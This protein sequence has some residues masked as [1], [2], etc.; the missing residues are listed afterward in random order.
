MTDFKE[1]T[2]EVQRAALETQ[3]ATARSI[4]EIEVSLLAHE[5]AQ[6]ELGQSIVRTEANMEVL[7][8][9]LRSMNKRLGH[10]LDDHDQLGQRVN[11]TR[12]ETDK[13]RASLE[14]LRRVE[15]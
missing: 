2:I 7:L 13:L 5:T 3:R 6:V 9:E 8:N 4:K 10:Y 12:R 11:E 14:E 15:R 1:S